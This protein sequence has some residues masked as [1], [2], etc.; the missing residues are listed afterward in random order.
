MTEHEFVIWLQGFLR[1]CPEHS[2]TPVQWKIIKDQ[3]AK[4][5]GNLPENRAQNNRQLLED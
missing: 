3:L 2:C 5:S 1:A 4:V